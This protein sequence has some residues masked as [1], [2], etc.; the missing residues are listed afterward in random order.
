M[1]R[2]HLFLPAAVGMLLVLMAW[3]TPMSA[4]G[5]SDFG[6]G[7]KKCT[8][9][10]TLDVP[11]ASEILKDTVREVKDVAPAH[12]SGLFAISVT[13]NDGR[14]GL[15]YMDYSKKYIISGVTVRLE[16]KQNI[17]R[18]EMMDLNRVDTSSI[19]VE[20]SLVV[21]NPKAPKKA[22]L[23]TDPLC[24]FCKK[25]HPEL[26]KAVEADPELVFFIK[27]LPLPGLHP[28]SVRIS[29]T[30]MCENSLELLESSFA[31]EKTPDPKC[32]SD[33]IDRITNLAKELG[34]SATP[35]LVLPDGRI[36]PGYRP[37]EKILEM[38]NE[39]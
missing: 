31:G 1:K 17:T 28:D 30:I 5:F 36:A 29:K 22:F 12:V 23:F 2:K 16:D 10:H 27:L 34:I 8:D 15:I 20:D 26:K 11:E 32:E 3:L 6:D 37:A 39:K 21:G 9:C 19:P 4:E 7:E 33:V 38:I 25:L 18:A 24:P 13:G 35:T 14:S